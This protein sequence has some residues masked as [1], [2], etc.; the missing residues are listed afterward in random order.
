M[1]GV[2]GVET[3][4]RRGGGGGQKG[5]DGGLVTSSLDL[6]SGGRDRWREAGLRPLL[7]G[8]VGP[9]VFHSGFQVCFRQEALLCWANLHTVKCRTVLHFDSL[10]LFREVNKSKTL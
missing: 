9:G 7:I 8:A 1:T 5:I 3:E 4:N 6:G 10:P 2:G